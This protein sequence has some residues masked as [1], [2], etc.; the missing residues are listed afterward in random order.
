V[1][2]QVAAAHRHA[3]RILV[4]GDRLDTDIEGARRAGM[5]SLLVLT[6]VSTPAELLAAPAHRRPS[7][8]AA[9]CSALSTPDGSSRIPAWANGSVADG[10]WRVRLDGDDLVL[11]R[12]SATP[13]ADPVAALRALASAAWA[14]PRWTALRPTDPMA[15]HTLSAL[16]LPR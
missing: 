2:F 13:D 5:A 12:D 16:H 1:L 7:H 6:G 3:S 11:S 10:G 8:L 4:V 14:H 9:D 15:E